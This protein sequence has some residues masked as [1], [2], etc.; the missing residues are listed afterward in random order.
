MRFYEGNLQSTVGR[1]KNG[2]ERDSQTVG[3]SLRRRPK[4]QTGS[5][6]GGTKPSPAPT[7]TFTIYLQLDV[8]CRVQANYVPGDDRIASRVASSKQLAQMSSTKY[9]YVVPGIQH[10]AVVRS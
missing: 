4:L 1:R 8:T 3:R 6:V 10:T 2:G 5:M 7:G 9:E